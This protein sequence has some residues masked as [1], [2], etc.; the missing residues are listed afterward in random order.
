MSLGDKPV[1]LGLTEVVVVV[2]VVVVGLTEVVV[3]VVVIGFTEV[4]V[5]VVVVGFTEVVVVVVV[6]VGLMEVVVVGDPPP[7]LGAAV[8]AEERAIRATKA[9]DKKAGLN[10]MIL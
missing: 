9:L 2:V 5:V 4:V 8:T 7:G 1:G 6:V 3:V 10:M